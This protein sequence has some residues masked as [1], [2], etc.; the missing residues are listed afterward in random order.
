MQPHCLKFPDREPKKKKK[1]AFQ[2]D[3]NHPAHLKLYNKYNT[4]SIEGKIEKVCINICWTVYIC[5]MASQA[6][7]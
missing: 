5:G 1:Q 2:D 4:D 7:S 3:Q 6:F